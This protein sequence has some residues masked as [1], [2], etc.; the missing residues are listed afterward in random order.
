MVAFRECDGSRTRAKK[1]VGPRVAQ[2]NVLD[3]RTLMFWVR[4]AE[5]LMMGAQEGILLIVLYPLYCGMTPLL[6]VLVH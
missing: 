5:L 1:W 4:D 2:T 3:V 6:Y